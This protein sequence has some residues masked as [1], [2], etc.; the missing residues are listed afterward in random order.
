VALHQTQGVSN[1]GTPP[2]FNNVA[3]SDTAAPAAGATLIVRNTSAVPVNVTLVTPG[4]LGSGD[5]YPD[6][7]VACGAGTG[8]GNI[9]PTEVW[10]PLSQDYV[11]PSTGL[12]TITYDVQTGIKAAVVAL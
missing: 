3:A 12:A 10:L 7:V 9:V 1:A 2:V 4:N 8:A 11:D 5:A 6:H